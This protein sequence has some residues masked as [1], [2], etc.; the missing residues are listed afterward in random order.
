MLYYVFIYLCIYLFT[1]CI[2]DNFN[3][4]KDH[5]PWGI[6]VLN[7]FITTKII[8]INLTMIPFNTKTYKIFTTCIYLYKS[9]I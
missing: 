3:G 9:F 1:F 2:N 7:V 8:L 5:L 6:N 4:P